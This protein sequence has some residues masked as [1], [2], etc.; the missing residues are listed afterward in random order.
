[1]VLY[2]HELQNTPTFQYNLSFIKKGKIIFIFTLSVKLE[3]FYIL[4]KYIKFFY[5]AKILITI[6]L[7]YQLDIFSVTCRVTTIFL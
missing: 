4:D 5:L 7:F 1:M 2:K 6:S 3:M